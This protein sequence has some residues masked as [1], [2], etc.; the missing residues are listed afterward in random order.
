MTARSILL[1]AALFVSPAFA[2]NQPKPQRPTPDDL[3]KIEAALPDKAPATPKKPRKLLVFTKATGFVHSSIPVGAKTFDLMGTKTGAYSTIVSDDPESFSPSNLTDVDAILM[4]STTGELF[5]PKG[6]NGNL[7]RDTSKPL[8]PE[9]QRARE[10]RESLLAFVKGGKGIMGIHAATDSSY[11]WKDWNELMGGY[12]NGH[13]W[14][15]ITLT[16]DDPANP[17]NA[18]FGGKPF[19][20]SDEIYTFKGA[21]GRERLRILTSIDLE[22]SRLDQGFNRPQDHD[23]W[24]SWLN[25][26][27]D[28][29]VFYCS[30]GH[31][32]ATYWNPTVLRHYLA[33]LQFVMGDLDA[34]ASPSGPL[35]P[36]RLA[37]NAAVAARAWVDVSKNEKWY[38]EKKDVKEQV[39]TGK[40]TANPDAGGIS[41]LQRTHH[42]KLDDK[43]IFTAAKKSDKLD[44]LLGQQVD[45]RGRVVDQELEGQKLSEL[46]PASVRPAQPR[47]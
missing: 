32:E 28:G 26:Y 14:G 16:L 6:Q 41:T 5:I 12:F 1:A 44:K 35:P 24:V 46:W 4:L 37:A 43:P 11:Q 40:L 22:A 2:Q 18:P 25:K 33:G 29:R 34:D 15:K 39:Y 27:G 31:A 23:Y 13:P 17:V 7:L 10:L 38:Q 45:I 20:I 42:Y 36:E 8:P 30:L 3:K 9:L 47:K 21:V 19:T